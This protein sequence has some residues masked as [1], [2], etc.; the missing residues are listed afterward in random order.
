MEYPHPK[1]L[2]Q[3]GS[4]PRI[5]LILDQRSIPIRGSDFFLFITDCVSHTA[6]CPRH[7]KTR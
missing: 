6:S 2:A 5:L 4:Y 3:L 1:Q 7:S